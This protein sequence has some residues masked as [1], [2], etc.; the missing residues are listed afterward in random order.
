MSSGNG[1]EGPLRATNREE[2]Y[3]VESLKVRLDQVV[4]FYDERHNKL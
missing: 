1:G 2:D 3:Q 4:K